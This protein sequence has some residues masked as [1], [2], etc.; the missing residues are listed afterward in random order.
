MVFVTAPAAATAVVLP[1]APAAASNCVGISVLQYESFGGTVP[2]VVAIYGLPSQATVV[3]I[4][5]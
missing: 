4:S 5:A 2:V 3:S 1:A